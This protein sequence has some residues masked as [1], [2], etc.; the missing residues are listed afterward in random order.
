[1]R[2]DKLALT[3]QEAFQS[4]M[5]IAGEREA[6]A[7]EPIHLLDAILSAGEH[8]MNAIITRIRQRFAAE[9]AS[10]VAQADQ[11]MDGQIKRTVHNHPSFTS[12]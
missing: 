5:S 1:M 6:S 2:L 12:S 4:A 11:R 7:V 10:T 9:G 8:N 3:A